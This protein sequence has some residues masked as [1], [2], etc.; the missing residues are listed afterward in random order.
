[1]YHLVD[2]YLLSSFV[3]VLAA[4]LGALLFGAAAVPTVVVANL[5]EP[6]AATVLR[7]YWPR[8]H[9]FAVFVGV[10]LTLAIAVAVPTHALPAVYTLMLSSLAALMT[11][12]F[13]VGMRLIGATNAA[14]DAGD[15]AGF[16]R[17]HRF[18]VLLVGAGIL[19]GVTLLVATLYILPGQFTFWQHG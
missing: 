7:A 10:V 12:C 9:R 16:N 13:F 1:M 5:A 11:L 19:A 14:K 6:D 4:C 3:C 17:L 2:A 8:Y 18:D 15:I